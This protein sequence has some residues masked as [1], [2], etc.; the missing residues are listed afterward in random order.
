MSELQAMINRALREAGQPV[1][2][3]AAASPVSK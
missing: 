1:P 2:Q 3:T